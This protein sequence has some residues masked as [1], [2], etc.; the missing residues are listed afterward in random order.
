MEIDS[1]AIS[2]C[3]VEHQKIYTEWFSVADSDGDGRVTGVDATNFVERERYCR[4]FD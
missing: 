2:R 1:S 4:D 3:S